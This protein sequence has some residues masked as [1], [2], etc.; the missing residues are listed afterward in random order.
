VVAV[1]EAEFLEGGAEGW[2]ECVRGVFDCIVELSRLQC[3]GLHVLY[4]Q[5]V[6]VRPRP[7]ASTRM[8]TTRRHSLR[9]MSVSL[10]KMSVIGFG[11]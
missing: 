7:N 5:A 2:V 8:G 1:V 11:V 3:Y 6:P 10:V 9:L 4:L